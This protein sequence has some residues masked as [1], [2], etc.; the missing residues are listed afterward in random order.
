LQSKQVKLINIMNI[1]K[2]KL[3]RVDVK[4]KIA[5]LQQKVSRLDGLIAEEERANG[6]QMSI[7][8]E[9]NSYKWE[10]RK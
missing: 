4:K 6:T 1:E 5:L 7:L 9:I 2:L 10:E 3:E 8:D